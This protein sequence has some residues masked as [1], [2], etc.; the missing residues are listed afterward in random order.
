MH[1]GTINSTRLGFSP[2]SLLSLNHFLALVEV[3][4]EVSAHLLLVISHKY[5]HRSACHHWL[6]LAFSLSFVRLSG[7]LESKD[8][9]TLLCIVNE[10]Q[11][12]TSMMD[13]GASYQFINLAYA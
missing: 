4:I 8:P 9:L 6:S 11:P 1:V 13:L 12:T 5:C 2:L 10:N 7:D 3:C